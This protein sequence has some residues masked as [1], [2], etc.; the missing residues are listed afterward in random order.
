MDS[1]CDIVNIANDTFNYLNIIKTQQVNLIML[2][3][4]VEDEFL[5]NDIDMIRNLLNKL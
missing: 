4:H 3:L 2:A 5:V 1:G